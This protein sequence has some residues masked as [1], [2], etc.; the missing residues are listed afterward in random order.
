MVGLAVGAS[1]G[2]GGHDPVRPPEGDGLGGPAGRPALDPTYR[3]TGLGAA[4]YV[5]V[6]LFE[7]PWPD[8]ARECERVLGPA[9]YRAVQVSP[10]QEHALVAGAPWWQ[11]YQPVSYA[12][13]G[14]S[15]SRTAF[16]DMV[17]RCGAAGVDVYVDA[18]INHMTAGAG[19][20]SAGSTYSKYEYP[21]IWDRS[22]FHAACGVDDYGNAANVQDCELLGLADLHTGRAEVRAGI[23]GYLSSLAALGVDGFRIDAAKHIQPV[24]L[25]AILAAVNEA[26]RADGRP[27]PYVVAEV[28]DYG[29]EAVSARDYYGLGW[30]SGGAADLTEFRVK[31]VGEKFAFAGGQR[32]ADLA[33]FGE[34]AWGLAPSDKAVVFLENHDTQRDPANPGVRSTDGD[35]Y[36]LAH[37]F[38]LA[39]PYGYPR[40]MSGYRFAFPGERD[41]GPPSEADGTT[42]PVVCPA[43]ID[44]AGPGE[45]VCEHRDATI[46]AM[47][48]FRRAVAGSGVAGWWDDGAGAVAFTR[49]DRGF[50]ALNANAHA[51]SLDVGTALAP[52]TWCDAVGGGRVVDACAGVEVEVD[53]DGRVRIDLPPGRAVV[54][55]VGTRLR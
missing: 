49:G 2:C 33:T 17:E 19:V 41:R 31:G 51:V 55:H 42:R 37:V 28:I 25:D 24:E 52:G 12:L 6:Q 10:P 35:A 11:R 32:P 47:V 7:W 21:G 38:L 13:E 22:D 36:R 29:G 54:L 16:V 30:G 8:V 9:G 3:A 4:G 53:G 44:E 34:A 39:W 14:R 46:R 20:G 23:A 50:V 40:V 48:G 1:V 5:F 18:V 15:G 45:W 43:S 26:A 27:L